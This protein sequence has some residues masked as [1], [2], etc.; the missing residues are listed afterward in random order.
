[1][2]NFGAPY[3]AS[4]DVIQSTC[5]GKQFLKKLN[6]ELPRN[7]SIPLLGVDPKEMKTETQRDA[8]HKCS[9]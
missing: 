5:C 7:T 8:C 1:M 9:S 4:E 3:M 6:I 2:W